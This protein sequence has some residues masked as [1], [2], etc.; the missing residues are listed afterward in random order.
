MQPIGCDFLKV[1]DLTFVV[2]L[3]LVTLNFDEEATLVARVLQ[4]KHDQIK[5]VVKVSFTS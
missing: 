5:A 1:D 3:M 4:I 2:T